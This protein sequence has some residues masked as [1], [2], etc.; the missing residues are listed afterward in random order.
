ME[1]RCPADGR[2]VKPRERGSFAAL[3]PF[4]DAPP[5]GRKRLVM[6]GSSLPAG[7]PTGI[8]T[9]GSRPAWRRSPARWARVGGFRRRAV[10]GRKGFLVSLGL[11]LNDHQGGGEPMRLTTVLRRLLGVTRLHVRDAYFGKSGLLTVGVRPSW[12]RSRCGA[13]GKRAPRYDPPAVAAVAPRAVGPD[14]GGRGARTVAGVVPTVRGSGGACVVGDAEQ[15]VHGGSGGAGGVSGA[16]DGPDD[17]ESRAGDLVASGGSIVERVVSRRLDEGRFENLRR[18]GIDEFSYRKRHHY[19]GLSH[20][21]ALAAGDR[22]RGGGERALRW[23]RRGAD[24]PGR[25]R[26]GVRCSGTSAAVVGADG[27]GVPVRGGRT[28]GRGFRVAGGR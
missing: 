7:E 9:I 11:L 8:A 19:P 12:R 4:G 2:R 16:D 23:S 20:A 21:P 24:R 13:C 14:A 3:R 15:R 22:G 6:A 17:G 27:P 28:G 25:V 18:I 26:V 1:V 5:A 10:A